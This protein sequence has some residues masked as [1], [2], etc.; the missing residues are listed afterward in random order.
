MMN[1]RERKKIYKEAI[2]KWGYP[3][4]LNMLMEECAELIQATSKVLRK[5]NKLNSVWKN[6]VEEMADVEIMIEQ[7]KLSTDWQSLVKRVETAKHDKMLRLRNM[8]D[9]TK[10]E[11]DKEE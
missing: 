1:K 11:E 3:L 4:Q 9:K 2:K 7:I 5:G 10:G 8:L 6:L